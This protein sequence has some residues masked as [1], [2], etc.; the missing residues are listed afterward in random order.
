MPQLHRRLE[1]HGAFNVELK[2]LGAPSA[3]Q[4]HER[5]LTR[6]TPL[7]FDARMRNAEEE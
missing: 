2:V 6:Q 5:S 3:V 4:R 7:A 1:A